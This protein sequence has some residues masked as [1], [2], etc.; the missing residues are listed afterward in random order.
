MAPAD[1]PNPITTLHLHHISPSFTDAPP[2]SIDVTF[3]LTYFDFTWFRIPPVERLLFYPLP[4]QNSTAAFF[5]SSIL[6]NL[7]RSLSAALSRILP[8]AARL[9]WPP[10]SPKPFLLYS[11][12][13]AVQLTVAQ[14]AADFNHLASD[15]GQIRDATE[16]H[17]FI[18]ALPSSDSEASV[19][20]LQVT[21]FPGQGFCVGMSSHHA[22]LDGKSATLFLKA[23]AHLSKS[24]VTSWPEDL[25]PFLD[26]SVVQ[27]PNDMGLAYLKFWTG[28]RLPGQDNPG[29][30]SLKLTPPSASASGLVRVTFLLSQ[31]RIQALREKVATS[32]TMPLGTH[33]QLRLSSFVL[34]F[35]HSLIC[36]V[37]AKG[38]GTR[39]DDHDE[40]NREAVVHF[41]LVADVRRRLKPP[42]PA[43]YLGNC[44]FGGH[45]L[46][47]VKP[48]LAEGGVGFAVER[49]SKIIDDVE[50]NPVGAFGDDVGGDYYVSTFVENM[51][52]S[53]G[54]FIGIAGSPSFH[55]Y[56][57]DFG[58]GK[59]KYV[60]VT[61]IDRTGAISLTDCRNGSRGIEVGLALPPDQ[62]DVFRSAFA[63]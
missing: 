18:P 8:L 49:I 48:L 16:S 15:V 60:E 44:V 43:N 50:E 4:P 61:S 52:A 45:E 6:P 59:P 14:S 22:V 38:L 39:A 30:R 54:V 26:R 63:V 37:K 21:L 10:D 20:A 5:T 42:L 41:G 12:S 29:P 53:G 56:D 1:S 34:T 28:L 24:D 36:L 17:P 40:E 62:M 58:W 25:I 57:T 46:V 23:W 55:V 27:D 11:P 33:H 2:P 31:N 32:K 9:T 35:A 19:I 47:Q 51:K 7:T 13:A 3:P